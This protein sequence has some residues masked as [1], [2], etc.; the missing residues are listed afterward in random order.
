MAINSRNSQ[1]MH[2]GPG[3]PASYTAIEQVLSISGPDGSAALI[4]VTYLEST[5]KEYLT[6]LPDGGSITMECNFT[7]G[8]KQ[9]DL[10]TNFENSAAAE[11]FK[12]RVPTAINASTYHNFYFNA[13]VEKWSVSVAVGAQAKLSVGLKVSG[14]VTYVSGA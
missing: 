7:G 6:D 8:T 10:F 4:D 3:S 9:M 2:S 1:I 13:V 11:P 14:S 5:G 12:L